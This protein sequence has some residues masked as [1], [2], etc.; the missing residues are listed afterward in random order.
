MRKFN[1]VKSI[2]SLIFLAFTTAIIF[3]APSIEKEIATEYSDY[4]QLL[5]EEVSEN[6]AQQ[7]LD[8]IPQK[9]I[10]KE[11]AIKVMKTAYSEYCGG[12]APE[13]FLEYFPDEIKSDIKFLDAA[14]SIARPET[15]VR[16]LPQNISLQDIL[17]L[18]KKY[19][20]VM[21]SNHN[22]YY[23]N[24]KE[25][26]QAVRNMI[27][28]NEINLD[29]ENNHVIR[30]AIM[31]DPDTKHIFIKDYQSWSFKLNNGK[32]IQYDYEFSELDEIPSFQ[33]SSGDLI[34]Y[35]PNKGY[36]RIRKYDITFSDS[37]SYSVETGFDKIVDISDFDGKELR[38]VKEEIFKQ[39]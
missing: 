18:T 28:N 33:R 22:P 37:S 34:E 10:T 14:L 25:F 4:P 8:T 3:F 38:V 26:R 20:N 30:N 7:I 2:I 29:E 12:N 21:L 5:Y 27:L 15:I 24:Q 9:M 39:D 17:F 19:P 11:F 36:Y 31:F 6:L 1:L 13:R 23:Q 32:E 35:F 16:S